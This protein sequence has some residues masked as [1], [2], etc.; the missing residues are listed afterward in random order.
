MISAPVIPIASRKR[1]AECASLEGRISMME[2]EWITHVS[3]LAK[4]T[5][6]L[7]VANA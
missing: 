3:M 6:S 4:H 7:S 5:S 2:N 1:T